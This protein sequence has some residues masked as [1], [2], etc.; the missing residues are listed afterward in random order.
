[1]V[2]FEALLAHRCQSSDQ[3]HARIGMR[4]VEGGLGPR[5]L[6]K[7]VVPVKAGSDVRMNV[8]ISKLKE[9]FFS[10]KHATEADEMRKPGVREQTEPACP[11]LGAVLDCRSTVFYCIMMM[12]EPVFV[13]FV[14]AVWI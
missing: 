14:G 1:M 5:P 9:I 11:V 13:G 8:G 3:S 4:C 7:S 2:Q 12:I 10:I 6:E